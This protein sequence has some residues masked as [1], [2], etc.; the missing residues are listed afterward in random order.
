MEKLMD[1]SS[2]NANWTIDRNTIK[3]KDNKTYFRSKTLDYITKYLKAHNFKKV[4]ENFSINCKISKIKKNT[5]FYL[6]IVS[7]NDDKIKIHDFPHY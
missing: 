7:K 3:V 5:K 1:A 2:T 6:C 4:A